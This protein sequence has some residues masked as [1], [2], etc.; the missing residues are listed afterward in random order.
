M[1][2]PASLHGDIDPAIWRLLS[3]NTI[4]AHALGL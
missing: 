3:F 4:C 2:F 1:L